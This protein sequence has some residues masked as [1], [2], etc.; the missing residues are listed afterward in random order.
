MV[1]Y[2]VKINGYDISDIIERDSYHTEWFP[3]VSQKLTTMDGVD[4]VAVKRHKG[5][6]HFKLNPITVERLNDLT[7]ALETLPAAVQYF[8]MQKGII[9]YSNM[10]TETN[11]G[12]FLSRC[13]YNGQDWVDTGEFDFEEL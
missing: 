1:R 8:N 12:D 5:S 4:H 2:T 9:L 6:L 7:E 10:M 3:V 13:K 11:A